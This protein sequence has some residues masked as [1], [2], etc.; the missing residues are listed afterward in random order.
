LERRR[1]RDTIN[2]FFLLTHL[3]LSGANLNTILEEQYYL[4]KMANI[5]LLDSNLIPDWER[6]IMVNFLMRDI[7]KE[8]ESYENI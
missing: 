8:Q 6:T 3:I 4:A 1:T 2:G 7:K 5:S